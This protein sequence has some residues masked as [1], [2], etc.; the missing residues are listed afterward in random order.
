[1]TIEGQ[2]CALRGI[3]KR[4]MPTLNNINK[5]LVSHSVQPACFMGS[6]GLDMALFTA[7]AVAAVQHSYI[8]TLAAQSYHAY[9]CSAGCLHPCLCHMMQI[10]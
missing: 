7:A 6:A 10:T 5:L 3:L 2:K 1:M 4:N 8:T 9:G